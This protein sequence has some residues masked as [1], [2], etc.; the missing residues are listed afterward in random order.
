M[1]MTFPEPSETTLEAIQVRVVCRDDRA[2]N[3]VG[4]RWNTTLVEMHGHL[5]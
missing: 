5:G 2:D 1:A 4:N 3:L